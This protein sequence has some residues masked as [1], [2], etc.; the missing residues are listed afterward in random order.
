MNYTLIDR[1]YFDTLKL[2]TE[3][4]DRKGIKYALVGGAGIQARISNILCKA[5]KTDISNAIG[6]EHLLRQTRDFDITSNASEDV[7]VNYFNELQALHPSIT[8]NHE[9]IRSKRIKFRRKDGEINVLINYQT[10]PQDLA[11]LDKYFYNECINNAEN[12]NLRY[13]KNGLLVSVATPEC[14]ITSKL[15]RNDPKDIWD[16]GALMKTMKMYRQYSGKFRQSKVEEYLRRAN[17]EEMIG[18]LA[19]I[20]KQILKE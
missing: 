10:G 3:E 13:G 7:F 20:K 4:F 5:K 14:L 2:L 18:R 12:L 15:T 19:E 6:L 16:I 1:G 8:V 9:G 17:K 11:G